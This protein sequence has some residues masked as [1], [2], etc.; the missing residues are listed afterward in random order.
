[1][2]ELNSFQVPPEQLEKIEPVLPVDIHSA[3]T[4]VD[5]RKS[6]ANMMADL[7]GVRELAIDSEVNDI[8]R[9]S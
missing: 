7:N 1:M 4:Y 9:I 5:N 8:T 3:V 6:L 2:H